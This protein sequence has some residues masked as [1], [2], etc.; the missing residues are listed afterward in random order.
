MELIF[1]ILLCFVIQWIIYYD[2]TLGAFAMG[3]SIT[4]EMIILFK[5]AH[6]MKI[7]LTKINLTKIN[8]K[9]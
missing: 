7:N 6:Y 1:G 8:L 5:I 4:K 3:T 2:E 9:N